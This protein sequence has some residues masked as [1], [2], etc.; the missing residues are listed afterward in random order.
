MSTIPLLHSHFLPLQS[1]FRFVTVNKQHA[2]QQCVQ[3]CTSRVD[4]DIGG[5]QYRIDAV[6]SDNIHLELLSSIF[7]FFDKV[8]SSDEVTS[9]VKEKLQ[10]YV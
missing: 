3:I 7:F 8:S 2:D 5:F 6:L 10:V 9:V 1:Y 4:K